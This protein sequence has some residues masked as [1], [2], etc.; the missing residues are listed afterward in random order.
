MNLPLVE[1]HCHIEGAAP[2]ELVERLAAKY[3][4]D[5]DGTIENGRY[6]WSDFT[7]FLSCYDRASSVFRSGDDYRELTLT[8]FRDLAAQGAI[9]GEVFASP[10]HAA[11]MG[12]SYG[13]LVDGIA[14]GMDDAKTESGIEG[15]ILMTCVRHLGPK[16]AVAVAQIVADN[17]H[18]MVTGF[19]MGGDERAFTAADFAPAFTIARDAGLGLTSHAGEFGGPQSVIDTLDHLHVTRIGHGVR[20]I[21]DPVL[22]ERLARDGIVLEVCPRSNMELDVYDEPSDHPLAALKAAGVKVTLNSDDPPFF[23]T[24]LAEDYAFA[25]EHSGFSETD[26]LACSRTAIEAA[27]VDEDTRA[28]LLKRCTPSA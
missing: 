17:P 6:V 18:P 7:E 26:L 12:I 22:V 1:I 10:D 15:R 2:P 24:S 21:E 9:Y 16:A 4:A 5:L 3:G 25:R 13:D 23:H 14:A 8:Y 28:K 19:G 27:F 11:A 20:S